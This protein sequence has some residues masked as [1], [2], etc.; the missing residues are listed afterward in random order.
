MRIPP[1]RCQYSGGLYS[2]ALYD[3]PE[4]GVRVALDANIECSMY[5]VRIQDASG[6]VA[7]DQTETY[8]SRIAALQAFRRAVGRCV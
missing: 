1:N 6:S 2:L 8:T 7:I 3:V 5:W 4:F